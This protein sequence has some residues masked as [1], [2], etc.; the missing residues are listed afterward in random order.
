MLAWSLAM[1]DDHELIDGIVMV[2][3]EEYEERASLLADDLCATKIAAAVPGGATRPESVAAGLACVPEGA[4]FVLVHDAARPLAPPEVVD[5]VV[6]ALRAGAE[7]AVPA[8]PLA[9]TVKRV[10]PDGS[11]AETLDRAALRAV[12]T[13]QGFPV[14]VLR[15]A[16]AEPADEAAT[17]CASMVERLGR[18]V[19][20]VEG[21]ERAF[22]VTTPADLARAERLAGEDE[23]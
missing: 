3:P 11:V 15:E 21:D 16:L 5:R 9:D 10:G 8:L 7:G 23:A 2:V 12:Q 20:C 19:V 14:S 6:A 22:K 1:L 4:A 18:P 17:D 13:P